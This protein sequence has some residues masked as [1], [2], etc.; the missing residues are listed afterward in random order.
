MPV[1]ISFFMGLR[2][3]AN[4]PIESFRE[5]GLWWFADLTVPDQYFALPIITSLTL[6]TTIEVK[7][8]VSFFLRLCL[9]NT[10]KSKLSL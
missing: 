6:W 8:C 9:E 4:L 5:G 7:L 10:S 1:F 2:K 3:M